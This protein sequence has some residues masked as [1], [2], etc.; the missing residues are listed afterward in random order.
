MLNHSS[1]MYRKNAAQKV[2]WYSNL[3]EYSQDHDL[4]LKL[5]KNDEIFLIK[6]F[7]TYITERKENM[8]N[9][10]SL[11]TTIIKENIIILKKICQIFYYQTAKEK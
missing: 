2:G 3:F 8:T 11:N 10:K 9:L 4:T 7:L 6:D 5:I 1:I